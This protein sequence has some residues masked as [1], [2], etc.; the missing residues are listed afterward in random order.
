MPSAIFVP[1]IHILNMHFSA[2]FTVASSIPPYLLFS[3]LFSPSIFSFFCFLCCS[4]W[5]RRFG[6]CCLSIFSDRRDNQVRSS[7]FWPYSSSHKITLF[8]GQITDNEC[9][10]AV[11]T[12]FDEIHMSQPIPDSSIQDLCARL[13]GRV[14][15]SALKLLVSYLPFCVVDEEASEKKES[16]DGSR[17]GAASGNPLENAETLTLRTIIAAEKA[18]QSELSAIH[19]HIL[20]EMEARQM[21]LLSAVVRGRMALNPADTFGAS[22]GTSSSMPPRSNVQ[23]LGRP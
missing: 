21:K 15:V 10:E 4:Y 23:S 8:V 18:I 3:A 19:D 1:T 6:F 5:I 14:S 11:I 22:A 7:L 13:D 2:N 17:S 20:P 12:L 9:A 16:K